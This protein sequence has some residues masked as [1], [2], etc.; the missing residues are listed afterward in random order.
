MTAKKAQYDWHFIGQNNNE[1]SPYTHVITATRVTDQSDSLLLRLTGSPNDFALVQWLLFDVTVVS[2]RCPIRPYIIR[3]RIYPISAI[4]TNCHWKYCLERS[5]FFVVLIFF[6]F[7][8]ICDERF[9]VVLCR[10]VDVIIGI[11]LPIIY[12]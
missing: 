8:M 4:F 6:Y 11:Y 1:K 3:I 2:V 7:N 12:V 10:L 9:G 5:V